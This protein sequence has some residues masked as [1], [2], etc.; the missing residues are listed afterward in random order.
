LLAFRDENDPSDPGTSVSM[1]EQ[2]EWVLANPNSNQYVTVRNLRS[3]VSGACD[4]D[5][6]WA[7]WVTPSLFEAQ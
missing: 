1:G 3:Y 5:G 4:D 6:N 7:Y 2:A